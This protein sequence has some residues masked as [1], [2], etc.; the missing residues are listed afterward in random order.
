MTEYSIQSTMS[1]QSRRELGPILYRKGH[2]DVHG[3]TFSTVE[4]LDCSL[5]SRGPVLVDTLFITNS[6]L[7][8]NPILED[9]S[10][11]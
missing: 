1:A 3:M 6:C 8:V 7:R 5:L 11:D 2:L 10:S 9:F 4:V